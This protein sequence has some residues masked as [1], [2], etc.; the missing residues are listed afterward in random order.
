MY[1]YLQPVTAATVAILWGLDSFNIVKLIAI[2]LIFSGVM[3]VN[4]SRA[5]E[6]R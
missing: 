6:Q 1:N 2:V 3:L 4:K 5:A